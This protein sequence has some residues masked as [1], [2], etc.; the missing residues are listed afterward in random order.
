MLLSA[1]TLLYARRNNDSDTH[2]QIF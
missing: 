2:T 1:P